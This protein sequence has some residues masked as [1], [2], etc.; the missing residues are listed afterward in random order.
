MGGGTPIPDPSE[1]LHDFDRLEAAV[2][3]L[4]DQ[5]KR[6]LKDNESLRR[7]VE[8]RDRRIRALEAETLELN[9]RRRDVAKRIDDLLA[10]MDQLDVELGS[11]GE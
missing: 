5:H 2:V 7:T 9:Q 11:A 10:Q 1:R 4:A 8:E 3:A 6:A